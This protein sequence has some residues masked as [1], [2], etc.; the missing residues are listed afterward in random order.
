MPFSNFTFLGFTLA[1]KNFEPPSTYGRRSGS[2]P[3]GIA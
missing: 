3:L 2:A 1:T